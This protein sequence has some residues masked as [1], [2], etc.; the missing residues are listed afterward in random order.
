MGILEGE[1]TSAAPS[2]VGCELM[3][4]EILWN[5]VDEYMLSV[6]WTPCAFSREGAITLHW[7]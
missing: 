6:A 7:V 5:A 1:D 3:H 4:G 2:L